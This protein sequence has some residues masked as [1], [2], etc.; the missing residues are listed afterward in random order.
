M[1]TIGASVVAVRLCLPQQRESICC[2]DIEEIKSLIEDFHLEMRPSC[3]TQHADFSN[4]C[5]CKAVLT[6]CVF[7]WPSTPL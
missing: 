4:V 2:Y 5:L 7:V 6:A 3:I 1:G